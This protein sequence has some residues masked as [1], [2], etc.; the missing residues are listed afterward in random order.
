MQ[1]QVHMYWCVSH[2]TI[3]YLHSVILIEYHTHDHKYATVIVL[4]SVFKKISQSMFYPLKMSPSI[5]LAWLF[6]SFLHMAYHMPQ[7]S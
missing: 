1:A 7:S 5:E 4:S 3:E 2:H 6:W